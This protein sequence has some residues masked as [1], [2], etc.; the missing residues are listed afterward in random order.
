MKYRWSTKRWSND[1]SVESSIKKCIAEAKATYPDAK[2]VY[3]GEYEQYKPFVTGC[4]LIE[5]LKEEAYIESDGIS[6]E[7]EWLENI[8]DEEYTALETEVNKVVRKILKKYGHIPNFG[9]VKNNKLY[10]LNSEEN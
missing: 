9:T 3:I 7:Q 5:H 10:K 6:E 1:G 2:E 8:N 4:W